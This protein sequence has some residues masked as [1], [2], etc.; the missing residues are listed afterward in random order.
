M[1]NRFFLTAPDKNEKFYYGW[2][3]STATGN[4][5]H[6]V[7]IPTELPDP[8]H[9]GLPAERVIATSPKGDYLMNARPVRM[10]FTALC[11]SACCVFLAMPG[12]AG[13]CDWGGDY[14][15]A[16]L[17][18]KVMDA[19]TLPVTVQFNSTAR[20][21]PSQQFTSWHWDFGDGT[22]STV[23]YNHR[24]VETVHPRHTFSTYQD[25][26]DVCF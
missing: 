13:P 19:E 11:L 21:P 22:T 15:Y 24:S 12:T 8:R 20:S 10:L 23:W 9:P 2:H 17:T 1:K 6:R 7:D 3:E 16:G 25:H 5:P 4:F 26:F 18:Y 14:P